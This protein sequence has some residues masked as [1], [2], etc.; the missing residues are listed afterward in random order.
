MLFTGIGM[1]ILFVT[2]ISSLTSF[3]YKSSTRVKRKEKIH[4]SNLRGL[5]Y[6]CAPNFEGVDKLNP[7]KIVIVIF[8]IAI[9]FSGNILITFS[10]RY[11]NRAQDEDLTVEDQR[12]LDDTFYTSGLWLQ[13]HSLSSDRVVSDLLVYQ[14]YAGYLSI[15]AIQ[16]WRFFV[17]E[18]VFNDTFQLY[19][20]VVFDK[21]L[22]R[23][24]SIISGEPIGTD[25]ISRYD[26]NNVLDRVYDNGHIFIY[27]VS[28]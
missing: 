27:R 9:I 7:M 1:S 6:F 11:I 26:N 20:Y 5:K 15:D 17:N 13:S 4:M 18:T 28:K 12:N 21:N 19:D 2:Y 10:A 23:Y 24:P 8:L 22:M 25:V 3:D 16:D 14:F